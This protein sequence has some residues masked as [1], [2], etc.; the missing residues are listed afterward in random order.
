MIL[1]SLF[2]FCF[3]CFLRKLHNEN[4]QLCY[5][6]L[7]IYNRHEYNIINKILKYIITKLLIVSDKMVDDDRYF[8][9]LY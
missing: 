4:T 5:L 8:F 1:Y 7:Y 3:Y 6:L 9:S 2:Y